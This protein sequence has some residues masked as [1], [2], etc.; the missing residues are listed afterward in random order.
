MLDNVDAT[1]EHAISAH[2]AGNLALA[3]EKYLEIL[4]VDPNHPD[5]N[6]NFGLIAIKME[7]KAMAIQFFKNAIEANPSITEY[8]ISC[9]NTLI[10]LKDIKNAQIA[11]DKAKEVGHI[12]E[13]FEKLAS[14]LRL[15]IKESEEAQAV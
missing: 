11:L 6:H 12:D 7:E 3:G 13:V 2:E 10:E 5:A 1:L 8:W 15:L 14:N 4:N 9:I